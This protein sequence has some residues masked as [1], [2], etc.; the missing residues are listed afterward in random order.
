MFQGEGLAKFSR[1]WRYGAMN[2]LALILSLLSLSACAA[3]AMPWSHPGIPK[4]DWSRDYSYCRR[5]AD[6][7][8]GWRE[9]E[10]RAFREYDRQQAKKRFD[11]VL[12]AC[13]TERG[14]VPAPRKKE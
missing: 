1:L 7:D 9:D 11:A 6:R 10:D 14:Y 13:M 5:S 4:E 3:S 2:R 8:V 12:A